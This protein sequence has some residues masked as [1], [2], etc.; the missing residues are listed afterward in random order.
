[1]IRI[2]FDDRPGALIDEPF[3]AKSSG[4]VNGFWFFIGPKNEIPEGARDAV[5]CPRIDEMMMEV[6]QA[7]PASVQRIARVG[8]NA[9]VEELVNDVGADEA[10]GERESNRLV[11]QND[12]DRRDEHHDDDRNE[13]F[14]NRRCE[15]VSFGVMARVFGTERCLAPK[16]TAMSSPAMEDVFEQRPSEDAEKS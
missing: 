6:V 10:R 1:M 5:V 3:H 2:S 13:R 12:R 16:A 8:V 7:R 15:V 4:D 14:S 9:S 11:C